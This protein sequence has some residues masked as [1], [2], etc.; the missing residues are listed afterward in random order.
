MFEAAHK[1]LPPV[2]YVS[3]IRSLYAD[4]R[5]MMLGALASALAAATAGFEAR[6]AV[7]MGVA[8]AFVIVGIARNI[9][10]LA[11]TKVDL[12]DDDV[13]TATR[14]ER[15]ATIGATAIAVTYGSWSFYS[16]LFVNTPFS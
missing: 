12:A 1:T 9:D 3:M 13:E 5:V 7:L 8:I 2:D 6:N 14:W 16:F 11:F 4:R 10:M 15:R